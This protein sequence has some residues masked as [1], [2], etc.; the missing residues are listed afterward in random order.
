MNT[1]DVNEKRVCTIP[2]VKIEFA[3]NIIEPL[4]AN[5]L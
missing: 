4:N 3:N 1:K 5:N 2:R